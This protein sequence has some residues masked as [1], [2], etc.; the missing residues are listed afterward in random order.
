MKAFLDYTDFEML[1][2]QLSE[3]GSNLKVVGLNET[4]VGRG[5]LI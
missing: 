2:D 3:S 1:V 5:K 4:W